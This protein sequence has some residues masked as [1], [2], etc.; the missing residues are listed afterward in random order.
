MSN[1]IFKNL[2]IL[3]QINPRPRRLFF[4]FWRDILR[5][6]SFLRREFFSVREKTV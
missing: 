5:G 1:N 6:A 4:N 2:K 3:W